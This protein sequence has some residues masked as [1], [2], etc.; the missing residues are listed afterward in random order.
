M[1]T[2]SR[3]KQAFKDENEKTFWEK[4]APYGAAAL[5]VSVITVLYFFGI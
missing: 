4:C 2:N 3:I 5:L 1:K